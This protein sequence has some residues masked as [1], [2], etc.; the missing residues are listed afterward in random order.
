MLL[1][2]EICLVLAFSCRK[3]GGLESSVLEL[4]LSSFL[5][6]G[7]IYILRKKKKPYHSEDSVI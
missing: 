7:C 6:Q 2:K 1:G 3:C 4:Y 5:N